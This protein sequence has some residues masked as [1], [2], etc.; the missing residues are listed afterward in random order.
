MAAFLLLDGHKEGIV[1][2]PGC[3]SLTESVKVSAAWI[4][5]ISLGEESGRRL[6]Q[7][8]ELFGVESSIINA[9]CGHVGEN[10][11]DILGRQITG[12]DQPVK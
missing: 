10:R 3:L 2:Q 8:L 12:S 5:C 7:E 9:G 4:T 1:L 11:D 6:P